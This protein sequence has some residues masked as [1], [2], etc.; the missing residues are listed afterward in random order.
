MKNRKGLLMSILCLL[1]VV[2]SAM[3][4]YAC[5]GECEHQWGEWSIT[6]KAT[7]T[8]DGKKEH[9]CLKCGLTE[10][11]VAEA[12]HDWAEAT[13]TTPKKCKNCSQTEGTVAGHT[14]NKEIVK[15][16]T[17]KTAATCTSKAVY[18]KSCSCGAKGTATFEYGDK[19]PHTYDQEVA[20][21]TYLKT[22]ATNTSAAVYY[23]SCICGA[24]GTETFESGTALT[25]T[26]DQ[27]VAT[28]AYLK[29]PATCTSKAVYYKSCSCGEK[30][31]ETF[32]TGEFA[33][34]VYDQEV[35]T[36]TYLKTAATCT[37]KAVY[38]KSCS[39]GEKG[40]ETFEYGDALQHV[41]NQEKAEEKYLNAAATCTQKATYYKSCTCG[42]AGRD[43]FETG[44]FAAHVY[45]QE[46]VSAEALYS[47]A[48]CENAA[49]YYNSCT[50]GAISKNTA[51]I[52][53]SGAALQH[54]YDQ[55]VV[56]AEYLDAAAT[57]TQKAT[58][59]YS[60]TCGAKGTETFETGEF[61]AHVYDKEVVSTEALY[62]PA[63]CEN[64]AKYHKSCAC[65]AIS[66]NAVEVFANGEALGHNFEE[67]AEAFVAATCT[68]AAQK[69][70]RCTNDGCQ[71][72][73]EQT[74]GSALGHN[75]TGVTAEERQVE[76]CEYVNVYECSVCGEDVQGETVYHHEYVASIKEAATCQKDGKKL[77]KCACGEEKTE[78]IVKDATG[79]NWT[80]GQVQ[81]NVR[82]DTCSV[83][84]ATKTVTVY[85]GKETGATS[86]DNLADTDISLNETNIAL[87]S[88]VIDAIKDQAGQDTQVSLSADKI[89]G[90]DKEDL[91]NQLNLSDEAI[92]K[93]GNS[94]IY[95]FNISYEEGGKTKKVSQFGEEN[96]VTITLPYTLSEGED[97]DS[98][99]VWFIQTNEDGTTELISIK[100]TYNNGYITFKTNHFSYY[101]VTRLTAE[102]RCKLY[103]HS[104]VK[105]VHEGSCTE[106]GYTLYF[107][108]R[109]HD[110]Y[111]DDVVTATGHNYEA[112]ETVAATCTAS[113]YVKYECTNENCGHS[114]RERTNALGHAWEAVETVESTCS[115]NGHIK[116]E[117]SRDNCDA[118]YTTVLPKS[119]HD[120][121]STVVAPTCEKR[122]YTRHEC[123]DCG[124]GYSNTFVAATGHDYT[125]AWTWESDYSAAAFVVTCANDNTHGT[126]IAA[127]VSVK[128]TYG[129]CVG[130][131][132]TTYTAA[133]SYK[134]QIYSD[135]KVVEVGT[136]EH[137][138]STDWTYDEEYHW[139]E[140]VCGEQTNVGEHV[141]ENETITKAPTCT[142]TGEKTAYCACGAKK[143]TTVDKLSHTGG[144]P[145][146]EK[147]AVCSE[148]GAEY[149]ELA[150]HT[151]VIDAAVAATCTEKGLTEGKHCSVCG[152]VL[153]AQ[154]EIAALGHTEVTDEAVT[155]TCTEKGLTEGKHCFVCG[156]VLV[157]QEEVAA[158]GHTEIVDEAVAATCT[159]TGLTEGKHCSE[160]DEVLVAQEVV[161]A[162]G[163]TEVIDA[164]VAATCTATG[165]TEGKHCS[166]CNEVL[167]AQEV[168]EKLAHVY[169]KEVVEDKYFKSAANCEHKTVY[170]KSCECG[171][172]GEETFEVGDY[173]HV[174]DQEVATEEY[175]KT[176]ATGTDKAVYYKSCSCGA[177]GEETFE[178]D[179]H[180]VC[181][182]NQQIVN[183]Q[184]KKS[185]ATCTQKAV[186]YY[187]C[188]CGEIGEE[189]FEYGET[190]PH[191]EVID[192]AVA[193]T[194][195]T[196]GL[197]EGKHCSVCDKVLVAQEVVAALGHKEVIDEAV[198][199]TCTA[200][201]LT[202]GKHCSVCDEVLVAQEVVA[203][204]GH[205]EVIDAAVAPTCTEKGK[206]EGKHCSVCEEVFVAQEEI[207]A[208]GHTEVI[209][210]AVAATCTATGLTEGK[211]CSVCDEVLVKQEVVE[212][213]AHVYDQEVVKD[214]YLKSAATCTQKAVYYYSCVCGACSGN[215]DETFE[216]GEL[217]EHVYENEEVT[218]APTCGE[219]GVKTAYCAC[220]EEKVTVIPATGEHT[221]A[222]GVCSVCG[223]AE[224]QNFY[225][226]LINSWKE[227]DGFAIQI[228]N[229]SYEMMS[230]S[231]ALLGEWE[232]IGSVKQLDIAQL[233]L[234]VEDGQLNG[235]ATGSIVIF[236]GPISDA[237]AVYEFDAL[238]QGGY[239]YLTYA[240]GKDA[241]TQRTNVKMS[242]DYVLEMLKEEMDIDEETMGVALDF[243]TETLIPT[244]D[245]LIETN[246]STVEGILNSFFDIIFTSEKQDDG[247]Y[248][249]RL[250]Y[251]KVLE[252]N[253]NLATLPVA[254]VIDI[255]FGEGAFDSLV[256]SANWLLDVTLGEVPGILEEQGIDVEDLIADINALCVFTGAPAEF[257]IGAFLESEEYAGISL[258]MLMFGDENYGEMVEQVAVML[259]ENSLYSLIAPD[260]VDMIKETVDGVVGMISENINIS[261]ETNSDGLLTDVNLS[262]DE[263]YF[264]MEGDALSLS[265]DLTVS[266]NAR[267]DVTW[268]DIVTNIENAIVAPSD[269]LKDGEP[270]MSQN[271]ESG[272]MTYQGVEYYYDGMTIEFYKT[273]YDSSVGYLIQDD[274]GGWTYYSAAY[275]VDY[276]GFK[277][278]QLTEIIGEGETIDPSIPSDKPSYDYD[279]SV[280]ISGST[281]VDGATSVNS[282]TS[283]DSSTVTT[284]VR[285]VM[286]DLY[287]GE[288]VELVQ[289]ETGMKAVYESGV[290]KVLTESDAESPEA[291]YVAIFGEPTW[292]EHKSR[293]DDVEYY[294]NAE[295]GEYSE[296]SHHKLVYDYDVIGGVCYDDGVNVT[297]TCEN[298]DYTE[299]YT[300]Y[301]CNDIEFELD[302][303]D[304]GCGGVISGT[305][306]DRCGRMYTNQ[307]SIKCSNMGEPTTEEIEDENG[308][309]HTIITTVCADCGLQ[310]VMDMWTIQ[311]S[312]CESYTY[313][314]MYIYA[315]GEEIFR[316]I[317]REWNSTHEWQ[318]TYELMGET[319]EDGVR[320]YEYCNKCGSQS[321]WMSKGHRTEYFNMTLSACGGNVYGYRCTVCKKVTSLHGMELGCKI[322]LTTEEITDENGNVIGER[323]QGTCP[324]C[325]ITILE[326]T[327]EEQKSSCV[328]VEYRRMYIYNDEGTIFE[329]TQ[330]YNNTSHEW[331]TSYEYIKG[332][333]CDE[334]VRVTRYCAKCGETNTYET[335]GHEWVEK[336]IYLEEL[337]LCGGYIH[338]RY[339]NICQEVAYSNIE[340][341]GC[342]WRFVETREDGYM[343][344][345][346]SNC[347]ANRL[348]YNEK[349]DKDENCEYR[350]TEIRIYLVK[351]EEVYRSE[352][353]WISTAHV[354]KYDFIMQ[355]E[356]C[357]D[358]Y[359]VIS[360]CK[361]CG[362]N[363]Q[364][365]QN[366][367][368]TYPVF[369]LD[370][371]EYD[372]CESHYVNVYA[373][374]C[375]YDFSYGFDS[376]NFVYNSENQQ[377]V[378]ETCGLT[379]G[380]STDTTERGCYVEETRTFS[381]VLADTALYSYET[382]KT[383]ANH[384]FAKVSLNVVDGVNV[385][386]TKCNNCDETRESQIL[387]ATL[388]LGESA[389]EKEEYKEE[390]YYYD[391]IVTPDVS[392]TYTITSIVNR[393]TYVT[394]YVSYSGVLN[395]IASNDDGGNNNNFY[396]STYLESGNTYVYRIRNLNSSNS[397]SI[398][399]I[400][401]KGEV[402]KANCH[403]NESV[404]FAILPDGAESCEDGA[405]YG[406]MCVSCGN[407]QYVET[408]KEHQMRQQ[409]Y[410]NLNE[411]GAC[412]GYFEV[413][414]CACGEEHNLYIDSCY[415]SYTSDQNYDNE[416]RIVTT[417]TRTCSSCGLRYDE[418]YYT[419]KDSEN[420]T[421][422]YYYTVSIVIDSKLVLAKEYTVTTSS[423]DY[424]IS[425]ELKGNDCEDGVTIIYSCKDC[426]DEYTEEYSY[427]FRYQKQVIALDSV[428][429]G[430][431]EVY[432]CA[433][434]EE[435]N[436]AIDYS[437]C[438]F[439]T[440][441]C[442][443]WIE[444]YLSGW[445][446]NSG[447]G[448]EAYYSYDSYINICAVTDPEQC[449][450]KIR[451]AYYWLHAADEC[452]AYEYQ[453]WQFGYN[454]ETGECA[455]ELTFKTGA[456][457]TLHSWETTTT[458]DGVTNY[459]CS[460]CA[461]HYHEHYGFDDNQRQISFERIVRDT[462]NNASNEKYETW[463]Y[464]ADGDETLWTEEYKA[465]N[466]DGS[467][468]SY[469]ST[470]EYE[471]AYD[472]KGEKYLS[473][474]SYTF[475]NSDPYSTQ[476]CEEYAY[477][478]TEDGER[479]LSKESYTTTDSRG[480]SEESVTEWAYHSTQ[481][482][483]DA[484]RYTKHVYAD[485]R[486]ETD[487]E[488]WSFVDYVG[489]FGENG[490]EVKYSR[491][492]SYTYNYGKDE[493]GKENVEVQ[494][495]KYSYA[496][497]YAYVLYEGEL[498]YVYRYNE[499]DGYSERYDYAYTFGDECL[500]T[501][502]YNNSNGEAWTETENCC[503][504]YSHSTATLKEPTCTQVGY[505]CYVCTLCAHQSEVWELTA[506][507]HN[508]VLNS[509]QTYSCSRCGLENIN[510]VSGDI[511]LEDLTETYGAAVNYVVGYWDRNKVEYTYYVSLVNAN[512]EEI[513]LSSIEVFEVEG[514]RAFAFSKAAV[515]TAAANGGYSLDDYD[516]RFAF[517]PYGA[518]DS[519]D[520]AIT[521]A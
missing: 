281:N 384:D 362:Y 320:V 182:F 122:G 207:A 65:G 425:G 377:Y 130:Y 480:N 345:E 167:V 321:D 273:N 150:A 81:D 482:I 272:Y 195:T 226:T 264:E 77:L 283:S 479:Y 460:V 114:Y 34:H 201:G 241:A 333:S 131:S 40:T 406:R 258:G 172:K 495:E 514:V 38:Y 383:Y 19:L 211:H 329:Y 452:K 124:Y 433:C 292:T 352:R 55:D 196:T 174:Y 359:T 146:C 138:F 194:C 159:A 372:C 9:T 475:E 108:V 78:T 461:S 218:K 375:G 52:F 332:D 155:P 58:Y 79:H 178:Y 53:V 404:D 446:G 397:E 417:T 37:S 472:E 48:T 192:A 202:E 255:Y 274:C 112:V 32:E 421:M 445:I 342:S 278:L 227:I 18:Y 105:Q 261:F 199:A 13:C 157:A 408:S 169:N 285:M 170:Y 133:V 423:H 481:G 338:Q 294:Y 232:L 441:G 504:Y 323:C 28:E 198:A 134:G 247:S 256:D 90:D 290:E 346:C 107:C 415:D 353:S 318:Y 368:S 387:Q 464:D 219:S 379:I 117:C 80:Q 337:G 175:L 471:Y 357:E 392:A 215:A 168:V 251:E 381:V 455:Y 286:V 363:D 239:V 74:E 393:D 485:G 110:S 118:A 449:A 137:N 180:T 466:A 100:A 23:K 60:C 341:Y 68:T 304:Y 516:V 420:C 224:S 484:R 216:V 206:T 309:K 305:R 139:K 276:Y 303:S 69:T 50:C 422:T 229:L 414:A 85:T 366:W 483:Y 97:V 419:V 76:G 458:D 249:V 520:Y 221:Y 47:A 398:A 132:K 165:L 204:L 120:M 5:F 509:E 190:L 15:E 123:K 506:R 225:I 72:S 161:A 250:D 488:T 2:F 477:A 136:L 517:V 308:V 236:N 431:A 143:V 152:E 126:T 424:Q 462:I 277:L 390:Y 149:G 73:Y 324:E 103:T 42:K 463:S 36:E 450:Y 12:G 187:S 24:K 26:F 301:G 436:V 325:G 521:F 214:E 267:I 125:R 350:S 163:H 173:A 156:E 378:C 115:E 87:D 148:C 469:Q 217:A 513:I 59:Y 302:L 30:G 339:C 336:E 177:K 385:L 298:C 411:Y 252:L 374:P 394:L 29:T 43:T 396:L 478:Y 386:T 400:F 349:S 295:T 489:T 1:M 253:E 487:E 111:K 457:R 116:Y 311:E 99:A 391:Y 153:V 66:A 440:Q 454:E 144:E 61:A 370:D 160:C 502:T 41:Y 86:S 237:D 399:F 426:D 162:L 498:Y 435:T 242:V 354:Y 213:L 344:D 6:T 330:T 331:Q 437:L 427:H 405:I 407:L 7:C 279:D 57:C 371:A 448:D 212:K 508:W 121:E 468:H 291:L 376:Y 16:A 434:G 25:H 44:E 369:K 269:D 102:E 364:N 3:G 88:G 373:C 444:G 10:Y 135:V 171:E 46:V 209:D 63:T 439:G 184:T 348:T 451:Y 356:S 21:D 98:I 263:F 142:Q 189:T 71:E 244:I 14:Y 476:S 164:A 507:D 512:G 254:E 62:S 300:T 494:E 240:Y 355:G 515:E 322:E 497:E 501:T 166:V 316:G 91:K 284:S 389:N 54:V 312:V 447:F 268:E 109:C 402:E 104:Y 412:Y 459:D 181:T 388:T 367:H 96:Y 257:D 193:A 453:T 327:W 416:G 335:W 410:V 296:E 365:T 282:A 511:V 429:G 503:R 234:Y 491:E 496:E 307:M 343:V 151:E 113:G 84:S 49:K 428:C 382:V 203:A 328:T 67:D 83:C 456:S 147:K 141:F 409:E 70:Y 210:A 413:S 185:D 313:N 262:V 519:V 418:S 340:D 289:T 140:C 11:D 222:D 443:M 75:T 158:L 248:V 154:E 293:V 334:G 106:D 128:T 8:E 183:A 230:Q 260:N 243:L 186:Y 89:E 259:R 287:S 4:F 326:E 401:S 280:T 145:T 510:G 310:F 92:A 235:A 205:K 191:T 315:D 20:T 430:Y 31:T 288:I 265:L 82:T 94:P 361:D 233:A 266:F 93:T 360:T 347:G 245:T 197:T 500:K 351:G 129:G 95:N 188:S 179:A 39:C 490:L 35:T 438:K 208:L 470:T 314:G 223:K 403:C 467:E 395:Q 317:Q 17:L 246:S 101:T 56:K 64:A 358:G 505:R 45:N 238:I 22:A 432:G 319:C 228:E 176:P 231:D 442:S 27:E 518:D 380:N 297:V 220:G 492:S 119:A 275:A 271:S 200:T 270:Q 486:T 51:E 473:K 493:E 474:K 465:V 127:N 33:P 306:C 499:K 299:V